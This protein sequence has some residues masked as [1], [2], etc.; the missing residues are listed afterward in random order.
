MPSI[1]PPVDSC[2]GGF[3][4]LG[5]LLNE[6]LKLSRPLLVETAS[7][8]DYIWVSVQAI[9]IEA[10]SLFII[11]MGENIGSQLFAAHLL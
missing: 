9:H 11:A 10:Q 1:V 3:G 5:L 6:L 7:V 8:S 4:S 2:F